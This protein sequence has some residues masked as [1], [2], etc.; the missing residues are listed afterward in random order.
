MEKGTRMF[1]LPEP[2]R[3]L[4]EAHLELARHYEWTSRK[5]TLDEHLV[6]DIATAVAMELFDLLPPPQRTGGVDA[7]VR[8]TRKTVQVKATTSGYDGPAFG[9]GK[10]GA[11]HLVFMR[12]DFFGGIVSVLYDGPE[13]T[14]RSLLP[15]EPWQQ[16]TLV[17]NLPKVRQLAAMV[18]ADQR[19]P[20]RPDADG[21]LI[22]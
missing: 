14:V 15:S 16:H 3:H 7:L 9:S 10:A 12:L 17:A 22:R 13:A 5:F 20:L 8:A 6:G 11:D 21:L 18:P 1:K 19:L 2:V 4:W